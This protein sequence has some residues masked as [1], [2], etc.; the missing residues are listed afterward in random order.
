MQRFKNYLKYE[1]WKF[2][3]YKASYFHF[4]ILQSQRLILQ[5][6][7][8][9]LKPFSREGYPHGVVANEVDCGIIINMFKLLS[10]CCA[11]F[12]AKN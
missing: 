9:S 8:L 2:N 10:C 1:E 12:M 7:I 11:H 4:T 5:S 3:I 6:F